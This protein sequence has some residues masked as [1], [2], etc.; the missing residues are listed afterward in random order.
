MRE[1]KIERDF[2]KRTLRVNACKKKK[3]RVGDMRDR[4]QHV[5]YVIFWKKR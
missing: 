4:Q 5:V 1:R 3:R 2:E